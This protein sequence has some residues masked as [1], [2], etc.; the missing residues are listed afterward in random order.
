MSIF[1]SWCVRGSHLNSG[2]LLATLSLKEKEDSEAKLCLPC[3][4]DHLCSWIAASTS[5]VNAAS[6]ELLGKQKTPETK[7]ME[8]TKFPEGLGPPRT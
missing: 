4:A 8:V 5:S 2:Q 6:L 7:T 1:F 3:G